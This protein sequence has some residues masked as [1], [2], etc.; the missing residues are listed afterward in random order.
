MQ[1]SLI[2]NL[3]HCWLILLLNA[4]LYQIVA[5]NN[6]YGLNTSEN[7]IAR[8]RDSS[9][10]ELT[11][12][13][14]KF[15]ANPNPQN[16]L[17]GCY[18]YVNLEAKAT[19]KCM[20]SKSL[21]WTVVIDI[22]QD[23]IMDFEFSSFLPE[24]DKNL[25]NDTNKNGIPDKYLKPSLNGQILKVPEI[26][27]DEGQGTH[28]V[29]WTVTDGCSN[30]TTCSS[31]FTV[32]DKK[33]PTPYCVSLSQVLLENGQAELWSIDFNKGS[34]DNCTPQN[35][36]FYT[37]NAEQ[38]V[39]SKIKTEEHYFKGGGQEATEEEYNAGMAQR[40]VPAYRSSSK[41][42]NYSGVIDV[43][44]SVWDNKMNTDFCKVTPIVDGPHGGSISGSFV[45]KNAES[46]NKVFVKVSANVAEFPRSEVFDGKYYFGTKETADY[47]I[48]PT[49]SDDF[50]NGIN[51]LDII[52]LKRH[53][54]GTALL[55]SPLQLIAADVN[56]DGKITQDDLKE[57]RQL[58]SGMIE[59]FS[60][61]DS[62]TFVPKSY[63]FSDP[64]KPYNAPGT[65]TIAVAK[66]IKHLDFI[67]IKIGD[68]D[69]S[70]NVLQGIVES[71]LEIRK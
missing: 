70:A 62:W 29:Y 32:D 40:W 21:K 33:A 26:L 10:I 64:T 55:D 38:P 56:R 22:R 15:P 71:N 68:L 34:F 24:T 19:S 52:I 12:H 50:T 65:I 31:Y 36:L 58:N 53:L 11:C 39:T 2:F 8:F 54:D 16:P 1:T 46:I 37:F 47:T 59:K 69:F 14:Q 57:L 6:I 7:I 44:M 45:T 63:V 66:H 51:S 18:G 13:D 41:I 42:F 23:E 30:V 25:L 48:E 27:I 17:G 20:E 43:K 28:K 4:A 60:N 67:G 3:K 5:A 49:K 61:N 35:E 9:E